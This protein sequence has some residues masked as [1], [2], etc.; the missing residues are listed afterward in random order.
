MCNLKCSEIPSCV[1]IMLVSYRLHNRQH[2]SHDLVPG[3]QHSVP[4][5]RGDS[6]VVWG[7]RDHRQSVISA[8]W[9]AR[10]PFLRTS[11]RYTLVAPVRRAPCLRCHT[12]RKL[13]SREG[14]LE[15]RTPAGSTASQSA[16]D[17]FICHALGQTGRCDTHSA[18]AG[19]PQHSAQNLSSKGGRASG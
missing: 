19:R 7:S 6:R 1:A 4:V 8:R 10:N 11:T 17:D 5:F 15:A 3:P 13:F 16:I 18:F 9:A 2:E 14:V 12:T